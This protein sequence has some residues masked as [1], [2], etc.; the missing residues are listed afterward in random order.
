MKRAWTRLPAIWVLAVIATGFG[1]AVGQTDKSG[2]PVAD[3]D[4]PVSQ[5]VSAA[6]RLIA[7]DAF[8]ALHEQY[9]AEETLQ[10]ERPREEVEPPREP[11][12]LP[13]WLISFLRALGPI[14]KIIFYVGV[15]LIA[16]YILY[17]IIYVVMGI[18]FDGWGQRNGRRGKVRDDVLAPSLK[19]DAAEARS[20]LDQADALAREGRFAEAVHLLLFR[21]IE[22]IQTRRDKRLS[23]ALTAREI[24]QLDDLPSAPRKAL[25]PIIALVERSFFGGREVDEAG[26]MTARKSYEAFAFGET[27]S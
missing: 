24:G 11:V 14:I 16:A 17:H 7:D 9:I 20:L 12:N 27:W 26:W 8:D 5:S 22:D 10:L 13:D 25:D 3:A 21:S 18:R 23:N 6:D 15:A 2:K 1:G 19:P 4:K